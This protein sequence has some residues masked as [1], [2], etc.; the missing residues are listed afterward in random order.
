MYLKNV[1]IGTV[2]TPSIEMHWDYSADLCQHCLQPI[3]LPG[4]LHCK[5]FIRQAQVKAET[6]LGLLIG[7][8]GLGML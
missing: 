3:L 2:Y 8:T 5:I 6:W 1:E 4:L 7:I